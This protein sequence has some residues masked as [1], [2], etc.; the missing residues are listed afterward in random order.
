MADLDH[1]LGKTLE[2]GDHGFPGL[3]ATL[4]PEDFQWMTPPRERRATCADCFRVALGEYHQTTQCCT[5]YPQLSNFV[6]GLALRDPAC[7]EQVQRQIPIGGLPLELT[8]SPERYRLSIATYHRDRFGKDPG[9]ICPYL[10]RETHQC[11]MYPY[12]NS[13]C[14]TFFCVNDHDLAGAEFW[15]RLQELVAHLEVALAQWAMDRLGFGHAFYVTRLDSLADRI[16]ACTDPATGGWSQ[17]VRELL[18]GEYFGREVE[19]YRRC[20]DLVMEHHADLHAIAR[21]TPVRHAMEFERAIRQW[22]PEEIRGDVPPVPEGEGGGEPIPSL[23]YK[24]QLAHRN[25]WQLP[26]GETPVVLAAGADLQPNPRD[27]LEAQL[28]EDKEFVVRL[29]KARV[30]LTAD[31]ARALRLFETP[32]LLDE[33]LLERPEITALDDPREFLA[34]FMRRSVLVEL[35]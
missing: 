9:A 11:R 35:G 4:L 8:G 7:R 19:F 17:E 14:S 13:V 24:L 29:E 5:Y 16:S 21:D 18:W 28:D 27:D 32:Q 34:V 20:A 3:W 26:F 25:L 33:R 10:H 31:Q 2:I 1:P 22:M 6:V 30:F 23:W 12:R 15:E